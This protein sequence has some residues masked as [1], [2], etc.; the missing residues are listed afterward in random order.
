MTTA[1]PLSSDEMGQLFIVLRD[2]QEFM[3]SEADSQTN[4]AIDEWVLNTVLLNKP[5]YSM[6]PDSIVEIT[7]GIFLNEAVSDYVTELAFRLFSTWSVGADSYE[8]LCASL[9]C[10][11]EMDACQTD[12]C[13]IP[14]AIRGSMPVTVFGSLEEEG[15]TYS[16]SYGKK[17]IKTFD[18]LC[19]NRH[20][21]VFFLIYLTNKRN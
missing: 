6:R 21:V 8:R 14:A 9:A 12:L 1:T 15:K 5:V 2:V 10:G 11:L 18:F 17:K 16:L 4:A 20:M 19:D 13:L 3:R 7:T